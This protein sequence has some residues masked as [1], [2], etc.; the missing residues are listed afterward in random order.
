MWRKTEGE[1]KLG[2][3]GSGKLVWC[4]QGQGQG[5]GESGKSHGKDKGMRREE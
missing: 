2:E 3:L 4:R 1:E 5:Q